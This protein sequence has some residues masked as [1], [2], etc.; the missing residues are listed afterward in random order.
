MLDS[1]NPSIPRIKDHR[2]PSFRN[3]FNPNI[4]FYNILFYKLTTYV[5]GFFLQ[6][7]PY[8]ILNFWFTV[9]I[10]IRYY[11][12]P[13]ADVAGSGKKVVESFVVAGF[14]FWVFGHLKKKK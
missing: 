3:I 1:I 7:F 9:H 10:G 11:Y 12:E 13:A 6:Q 5:I 14:G 8:E 4:A 2:I